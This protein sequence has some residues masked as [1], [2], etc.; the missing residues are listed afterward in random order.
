MAVGAWGGGAWQTLPAAFLLVPDFHIYFPTAP[1]LLF[2][3][4]C[5]FPSWTAH[6]DF[7]AD[8]NSSDKRLLEM[9][10]FFSDNLI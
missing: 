2:V 3:L 4:C 8:Q 9:K 6:V 5:F 10:V 1:V 7:S